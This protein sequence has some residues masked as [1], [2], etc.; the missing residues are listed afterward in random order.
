MKTAATRSHSQKHSQDN[1]LLGYAFTF[2]ALICLALTVWLSSLS[3]TTPQPVAELPDFSQYEVISER[4]QAFFDYLRPIAHSQNQ[5]VLER[6]QWLNKMLRK[7]QR[8]ETLTPWQHQKLKTL[9]DNHKI[10]PSALPADLI[11]ALLA[12]MDIIPE[13]MILSQAAME[14][15]W[16]QSRFAREANNLFGQWCFSKGCGLVPKQRNHGAHHEVAR[17]DS[18]AD[19]IASYIRNINSHRAYREV[20]RIRLEQRQQNLEP[21]ALAMINGLGSYSEK[22]Q[23]YIDELRRMIIGNQ[24]ETA[25]DNTAIKPAVP[26]AQL[27]S[28]A[29]STTEIETES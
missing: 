26:A 6:R 20:R 12:K 24:L 21:S 17:F 1:S 2:F 3:S 9:A 8:S 27:D 15:A 16:G 19:A 7:L 18:V 25:P 22:G 11:P 5:K 4:K 14:S 28:A 10:N 29:P 23:A 13:A